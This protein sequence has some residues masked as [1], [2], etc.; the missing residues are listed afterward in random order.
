MGLTHERVVV[1]VEF[2]AEFTDL[3]D[4][5]PPFVLGTD[6][7]RVERHADVDRH[8]DGIPIPTNSPPGE[9]P[10]VR[11]AER[12][13]AVE[14][15]SNPVEDDPR[16][17]PVV[18]VTAESVR[19]RVGQLDVAAGRRDSGEEVVD[20]RRAEVEEVRE[21]GFLFGEFRQRLDLPFRRSENVAGERLGDFTGAVE[22]DGVVGRSFPT[23]RTE[24]LGDQ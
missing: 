16:W 3:C 5:R 1:H 18:R 22:I 10:V 4:E 24:T 15:Q 20:D 12:D 2:V 23:R 8:L 17:P 13:D 9:V 11:V 14:M 6:D 19:R 7:V 21:N